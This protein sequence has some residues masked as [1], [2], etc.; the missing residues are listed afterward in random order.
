MVADTDVLLR[1]RKIE[2][3]I[4]GLQRMVEDGRRCQEL[5]TQVMAV[6]SALDRVG[7]SI[8]ADYMQH[9]LSADVPSQETQAALTE[10]L[11]LFL[12][13]GSSREPVTA[14]LAEREGG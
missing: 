14:D 8:V 4:R 2:G 12:R 9:C 6:R 7:V 3:Q 11:G 13:L 1:L 10:A 5:V